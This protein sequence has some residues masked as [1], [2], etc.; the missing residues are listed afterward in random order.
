MLETALM[1]DTSSS[2]ILCSF[3]LIFSAYLAPL[4]LIWD[5]TLLS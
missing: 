2:N 5:L 4:P 1:A 3:S